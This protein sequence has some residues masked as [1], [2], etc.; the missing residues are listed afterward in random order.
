MWDDKKAFVIIQSYRN[1]GFVLKMFSSSSRL[2][3]ALIIWYLFIKQPSEQGNV[4]NP[5]A[6]ECLGRARCRDIG[7]EDMIPEIDNDADLMKD[8]RL[9]D[10]SPRLILH[11][12]SRFPFPWQRSLSELNSWP[13][14]NVLNIIP[15][16]GLWW[17]KPK[18]QR[19]D[20]AVAWT[21][22]TDKTYRYI[23]Y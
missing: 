10:W 7:A 15:R 22:K 18:G 1:N 14:D 17:A 3:P 9:P 12:N 8:L 5:M 4:T 11:I 6:F 13:P 20:H 21:T 23:L 19:G 16:T 2:C